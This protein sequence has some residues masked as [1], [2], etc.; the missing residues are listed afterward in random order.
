M[1]NLAIYIFLVFI[2]ALCTCRY[3]YIGSREHRL[4][5]H[6]LFIF[7]IWGL[8]LFYAS[9]NAT[10]S[11]SYEI[12]FA[13]SDTFIK[14]FRDDWLSFFIMYV[15][16][17]LTNNYACFR[18]FVGT[19]YFYPLIYIIIKEK[20][21]KMD[22]SFLV[23]L[24]I[25]YPFFISIVTLRNTMATSV[26]QIALYKYFVSKKKA[27]DVLAT[28]FFLAIASMLH[29]S[30]IFFVLFYAIYLMLEKVKFVNG[31]RVFIGIILFFDAVAIFAIKSGM[32]TNL[33][34]KYI[35]KDTDV[36]FLDEMRGAGNGWIL[37]SGVQIIFFIMIIISYKNNKENKKLREEMNSIFRLN[38][39]M[40]LI[41]PLYAINI[42]FFR[43][44]RNI[45]ILN[46]I[47]YANY[48]GKNRKI[49]K[50]IV[51]FL[52]IFEFLFDGGLVIAPGILNY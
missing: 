22:M 51:I 9:V 21:E 35:T 2:I 26:V 6:A 40:L 42:I 17:K 13:F 10:D 24:N 44:Y 48:F 8:F 52:Y 25:I 41:F 1:Y 5:S 38:C 45:L 11:I 15:I 36:I 30:A 27:K 14:S 20:Y 39:V 33:L 19:L 32:L 23:L 37:L 49:Y 18:L 28:F 46:S 50:L 12:E 31:E 34:Y 7:V 47:C 43:L 16:K 4:I 3:V 29:N